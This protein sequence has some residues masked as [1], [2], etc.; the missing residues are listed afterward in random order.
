[1]PVARSG[2][3][4]ALPLDLCAFVDAD[5]RDRYDRQS[6]QQAEHGRLYGACMGEPQFVQGAEVGVG[7]G[8][9][10]RVLDDERAP[11]LDHA[12]ADDVWSLLDV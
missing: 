4:S 11:V 9:D 7:A 10:V 8:F 12:D 1:M 3:R 6:T 5:C 2:F